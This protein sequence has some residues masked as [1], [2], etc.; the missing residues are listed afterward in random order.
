MIVSKTK[1][2]KT[3]RQMDEEVPGFQ[4]GLRPFNNTASEGDSP[5]IFGFTFSKYVCSCSFAATFNGGEQLYGFG[6]I[7][8][9]AV[10]GLEK[11]VAWQCIRC[12]CISL[13]IVLL[14]EVCIWLDMLK[15]RIPPN[16]KHLK[17]LTTIQCLVTIFSHEENSCVHSLNH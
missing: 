13:D 5:Q 15:L 8:N 14:G 6:G 3:R 10:L 7:I 16:V 17:S 4:L 1:E 2:L 12:T 11:S 9:V